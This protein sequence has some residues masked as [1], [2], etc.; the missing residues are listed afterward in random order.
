MIVIN[1]FKIKKLIANILGFFKI[2]N[3]SLFILNKKYKNNY[4]R[5]INYHHTQ[6]ND[7][8]NFKKQVMYFS[9]KF[10]N[11]NYDDFQ[12]FMKKEKVYKTKP[13]LIICFDDGFIDNYYNAYPILKEYN[14]T[15]WFMIPSNLI[16]KEG[17]L[18]S[19]QVKELSNNSII[20]CHTFSHHRMCNSDT[21]EILN[22]EIVNS[23]KQLERIIGK[24]VSIFCWVGG[25]ENHYTKAASDLIISSKYKYGFMTNSYPVTYETNHFFIQRT[26]IDASWNIKLLKYQI[27]MLN[28]KRYKNKRDII[29]KELTKEK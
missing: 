3:I 22:N 26:N 7:L 25:E 4:I 29:L 9:Q 2:T 27:S 10:N 17:Y 28:D 18:T 16:D 24:E 19:K 5:V 8:I 21:F 11:V 13:G 23:K 1:K 15:G 6:T 20:G 12:K 14:F